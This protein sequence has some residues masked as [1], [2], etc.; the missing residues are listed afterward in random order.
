MKL[1]GH[2]RILVLKPSSLGD[3][4]H[5]LPAV[6]AIS[7]QFPE[8]R[9]DWLANTEWLPLL[10]G[11]PFLRRTVPFPRKNFRGFGG[12]LRARRWAA[13][14]FAS[15]NYDV[16]LD[17]QGLLRSALLAKMSGARQRIGFAQAREGAANLYHHSICVQDWAH[18]HAVDRYRSLVE[19]LGVSTEPV[20]FPLPEG[21]PVDL[22][23]EF[24]DSAIVLHPFSRGAGKSLSLA[25]VEELCEALAPLPVILAGRTEHSSHEGH[26][27]PGQV[28]DLLNRT[29]LAELIFL[30]RQARGMISVDS[31]PMHLA[32]G[33]TDRVLSLHTWTDPGMV[34]PWRPG[35][36]VYRDGQFQQVRNLVAGQFPERRDQKK[37]LASQDRLY[38]PAEIENI[39]QFVSTEFAA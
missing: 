20:E 15:E 18:R 38:T 39:A 13:T 12:L 26:D 4:V 32:A 3:I 7:R 11:L 10:E 6:S 29:D 8:T 21:T 34:G 25:E 35:S 22:P 5:T 14:E 36:W 28:H 19:S 30:L 33:I 16:A 23:K 24:S 2:E 9:I 37:K 31:G 27:W 1:E 17:F